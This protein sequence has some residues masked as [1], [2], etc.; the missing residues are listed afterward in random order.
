MTTK[1]KVDLVQRVPGNW[2]ASK[3]FVYLVDVLFISFGNLVIKRADIKNY[4][5]HKITFT[6]KI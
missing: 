6:L 2:F 5:E 4:T 3:H 1:E